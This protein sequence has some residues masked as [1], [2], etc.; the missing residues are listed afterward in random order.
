MV[1]GETV[2]ALQHV[3]LHPK[4]AALSSELKI[5]SNSSAVSS[6]DSGSGKTGTIWS[7]CVFFIIPGQGNSV[8]VFN[9]AIKSN[10]AVIKGTAWSVLPGEPL[11]Q[12]HGVHD[13][14]VRWVLLAPV[15]LLTDCL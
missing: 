10:L 8:F 13:P 7:H 4:L 6:S 1:K 11:L 5:S 12:K 2:H 9:C 15:I 14:M 3:V